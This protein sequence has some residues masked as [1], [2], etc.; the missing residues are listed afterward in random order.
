MKKKI[1]LEIFRGEV[2]A[3]INNHPIVQ[4]NAYTQ[5]F[6]HGDISLEQLRH[7]TKQ[8]SVFSH[9]FVEAQLRKCLNALDLESYRASKEILL[10]ELGV[11]FSKNGSVEGGRFRF[12][13]AHFEWL[14]DFAKPLDLRFEQLGKRAYGTR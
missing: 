13:A 9:L 6:S 8:F 7:F 2:M 12:S 3:L 11:S 14:A 5:W 1:P 4:A 10:N